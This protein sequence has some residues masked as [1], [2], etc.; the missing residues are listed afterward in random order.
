VRNFSVAASTGSTSATTWTSGI[1]LSCLACQPACPAGV[2]Y[3]ELLETTRDFIE[4]NHRR[5]LFEFLM[6]RVV[7]HQVFPYPWR[8]RLATAP[9]KYIRHLGLEKFL[10]KFAGDAQMRVDWYTCR[11][12]C[13]DFHQCLKTGCRIEQRQLDF[14]APLCQ[15]V[16]HRQV[17]LPERVPR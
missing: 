3:G 8:M 17:V 9:V 16:A 6:R 10:P 12:F 2:H 5:S 11:W 15:P 7:I 13:E 1:C 14:C 4:H